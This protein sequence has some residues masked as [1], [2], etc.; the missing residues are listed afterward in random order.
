MNQT[1]LMAAA[2][3]GN[4]ALV[5]ALLERGAD[6]EATDHYGCNALHVALREAFRD[7]TFAQGPTAALYDLLAPAH[8]DVKASERLVRIDKH[9]SEYFLFQT[10]WTLFKS[11][12]VRI[13]RA[14]NC[15]LDTK[16]ILRA[17]EALPEN[18][19]RAARN[20]RQHLSHVLSRNEVER[21][22]AY[23]RALFKRAA[24]GWYQFN[25]ALEVR[26]RSSAGEEL[27]RP[28]FAALNLP[29]IGEFSTQYS[30]S[31]LNEYLTS[32]GMSAGPLPIM[33]ERE[34]ARLEE[35]ARRGQEEL[36]RQEAQRRERESARAELLA[37]RERHRTQQTTR[38]TSD[39]KPRWGTPEARQEALMELQRRIEKSR[40]RGAKTDED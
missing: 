26:C 34:A 12:F 7:P 10:F 25:P 29:L 11:R 37:Q 39:T 32:A 36:R 16:A 9:L 15:A 6:R 38:S 33:A 1:P 30:R 35:K 4:T 20:K 18:V 21:D 8:V 28:V 22:Y 14:L 13:D 27:W 31:A 40:E 17:W 23:N 5:E 19:L 2:A 3:A 24:H